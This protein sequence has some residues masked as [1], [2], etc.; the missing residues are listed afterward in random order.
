[1]RATKPS[2][3]KTKFF[4]LCMTPFGKPV[5]PEV[6]SVR[7]VA[8]LD[9]CDGSARFGAC[10]TRS[11][12]ARQAFGFT[13]ERHEPRRGHDGSHR[14][15]RRAERGGHDGDGFHARVLKDIG[16]FFNTIIRIDRNEDRA[17]AREREEEHDI[18]A[19]VRRHDAEVVAGRDAVR[20]QHRRSALDARSRRPEYDNARIA[21]TMNS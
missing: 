16:G 8:S 9:G 18:V 21:N 6:Y 15:A 2:P 7:H 17:Q 3:A 5:V 10:A 1:M 19:A 14:L 4:W 11:S 20:G 12:N 13:F